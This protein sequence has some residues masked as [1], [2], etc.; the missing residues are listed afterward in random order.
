M[1]FDLGV[2]DKVPDNGD[3]APAL[4]LAPN[5]ILEI[6]G[7]GNSGTFFFIM[8]GPLVTSSSDSLPLD[9]ELFRLKMT[10]VAG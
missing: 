1:E 10:G 9:V 6:G 2:G 5:G 3:K 8:F 7:G 4:L